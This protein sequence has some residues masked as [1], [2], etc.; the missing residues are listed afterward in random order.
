MFEGVL[1]YS[2]FVPQIPLKL[3]LASD[4]NASLDTPSPLY[5]SSK[6]DNLSLL[7]FSDVMYGLSLSSVNA[8]RLVPLVQALAF[9]LGYLPMVAAKALEFFQ[10]D[11]HASASYVDL[12]MCS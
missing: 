1:P 3:V 7:H 8:L 12:N 11:L 6:R 5:V 9:R 4:E 2:A 10:V